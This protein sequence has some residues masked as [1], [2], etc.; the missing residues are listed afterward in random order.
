[1][2]QK[3]SG[4]QAREETK[5]ITKHC[6][7]CGAGFI[8]TLVKRYPKGDSVIDEFVRMLGRGEVLIKSIEDAEEDL[9][10]GKSYT[11]RLSGPNPSDDEGRTSAGVKW[12]EVPE[13][14]RHDAE[15][16]DGRHGPADTELPDYE[17]VPVPAALLE[18]P[19]LHPDRPRGSKA[20]LD[21]SGARAR[22]A[23]ARAGAW[24]LS[25]YTGWKWA[26]W[27][28]GD[29]GWLPKEVELP[30]VLRVGG[31]NYDA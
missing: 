31:R 8:F 16:I 10:E 6:P 4:K 21:A 11:H 30:E 23:E 3:L 9:R 26:K 5:K 18:Q 2:A 22:L 15:W 13:H 12:S 29:V 1:M 27:P 25:T 17:A 7:S 20:M 28:G 14:S 19:R 24:L